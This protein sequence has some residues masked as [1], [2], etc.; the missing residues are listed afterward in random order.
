VS[1]ADVPA[2]EELYRQH[3]TRLFNLAWRMCGTRAD[4]EDLLQEIF[5]LAYRKLPEFRGDST[6]GTWL[7]RLAMNRC[8]DHLK[9]RQTRASGMTTHLDE[10]VIAGPKLV[11]DGGLN[12]LDLERAI[13]RLPDGA[14]AAFVL[15]DVEGFQHH[16]IASI[17]GI[18]EGTSK[19]QVHKARL[20]LRALLTAP[21]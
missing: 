12:R 11:A 18:S 21:V 9:S 6:V 16:E 1:K 10:E 5:L 19:S 13:A 17:L 15:H 8:L 3:S 14:R 7:Y 2:F 20:K 4:A